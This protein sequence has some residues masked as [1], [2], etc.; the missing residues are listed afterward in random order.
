MADVAFNVINVLFNDERWVS[1]VLW[2]KFKILVVE[3]NPIQD[4]QSMSICEFW[5]GLE[6]ITFVYLNFPPLEVWQ[7]KKKMHFII[8]YESHFVSHESSFVSHKEN[9]D[10][11]VQWIREQ[12]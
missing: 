5:E 11:R 1:L 3:Y 9:T 12:P 7:L 8:V 6:G 10:S 4:L 2:N